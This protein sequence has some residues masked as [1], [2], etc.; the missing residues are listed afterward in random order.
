MMIRKHIDSVALRKATLASNKARW[1]FNKNAMKNISQEISFAGG[2]CNNGQ[3]CA[4]PINN[5]ALSLLI[6]IKKV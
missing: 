1:R 2:L 5:G 4:T 3:K 6:M